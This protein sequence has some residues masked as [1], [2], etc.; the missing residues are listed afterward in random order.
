MTDCGPCCW[1]MSLCQVCPPT[2]PDAKVNINIEHSTKIPQLSHDQ[3]AYLSIYN[4]SIQRF[5]TRSIKF[6]TAYYDFIGGMINSSP[7]KDPTLGNISGVDR[8]ECCEGDPNAAQ[9]S[10]AYP[11]DVKDRVFSAWQWVWSRME[12]ADS[13]DLFC[14]PDCLLQPILTLLT[15]AGGENSNAFRNIL[16]KQSLSNL[17]ASTLG[18]RQNPQTNACCNDATACAVTVGTQGAGKD[19]NDTQFFGWAQSVISVIDIMDTILDSLDMSQ[20]PISAE[21]LLHKICDCYIKCACCSPVGDLPVPTSVC[22]TNDL[23]CFDRCGNPYSGRQV[24]NRN[25][26]TLNIV[27]NTYGSCNSCVDSNGKY[28]PPD[29]NSVPCQEAAFL[30]YSEGAGDGDCCLPG[31]ITCADDSCNTGNTG[32]IYVPSQRERLQAA[33]FVL[34]WIAFLLF[35]RDADS[36]QFSDTAAFSKSC[37]C[38]EWEGENVENRAK[39]MNSS[40]WLKTRCKLG[41]G[42][43]KCVVASGACAGF[44]QVDDFKPMQT[45]LTSMKHFIKLLGVEFG[46]GYQQNVTD[47]YNSLLA[48]MHELYLGEVDL[49]FNVDCA[50][51]QFCC[52][53]EWTQAGRVLSGARGS[54]NN[55]LCENPC[56]GCNLTI[57]EYTIQCFARLKCSC[58]GPTCTQCMPPASCCNPGIGKDKMV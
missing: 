29:L 9:P 33:I 44:R 22:N 46:E 13:F 43:G 14:E 52:T 17:S 18:F 24:I 50:A 35:D 39:P 6:V 30:K 1:D 20:D 3:G 5:I 38:P 41:T 48:S 10:P 11:S 32:G 23:N 16:L 42:N 25:T 28:S 49:S 40:S 19:Y 12:A 58:I 7:P 2:C 21:T 57:P 15:L 4:Y 36:S 27:Q 47:T 37:Y 53:T 54:D 55:S 56:A 45:M 51:P 8:G 26:S 31:D 34:D